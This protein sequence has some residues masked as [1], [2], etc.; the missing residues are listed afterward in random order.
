MSINCSNASCDNKEK[1]RIFDNLSRLTWFAAVLENLNGP[2]MYNLF[3][4]RQIFTLYCL[5][6]SERFES[7]RCDS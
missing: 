5:M 1:T 7:I 3:F 2:E 4:S 6:K